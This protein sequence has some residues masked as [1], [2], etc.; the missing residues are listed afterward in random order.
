MQSTSAA[1]KVKT[2]P[3]QLIKH[4]LLQLS[5]D[6]NT[7]HCF[8][9]KVC[10]DCERNRECHLRKYYACASVFVPLIVARSLAKTCV[11]CCWPCE[12]LLI[13]CGAGRRRSLLHNSRLSVGTVCCHDTAWTLLT[14]ASSC[15]CTKKTCCAIHYANVE[16]RSALLQALTVNA[17]DCSAER[18]YEQ[19]S[20]VRVVTGDGNCLHRKPPAAFR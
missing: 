3:A 4:R 14:S 13:S 6:I 5:D 8:F 7:A 18:H 19:A 2:H 15:Y 12:A 20:M 9:Q 11:N 17:V 1:Q 16:V 10:Y